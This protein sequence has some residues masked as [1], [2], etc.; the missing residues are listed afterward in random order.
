M[1]IELNSNGSSKQVG[2]LTVLT[3]TL[4]YS[5]VP[6]RKPHQ[7]L[8]S[9]LRSRYLL[10]YWVQTDT[11]NPLISLG[12]RPPTD[13]SGSCRSRHIFIPSTKEEKKERNPPTTLT[14]PDGTNRNIL[15]HRVP[16]PIP[17]FIP[18]PPLQRSHPPVRPLL[19]VQPIHIHTSDKKVLANTPQLLQLI[20]SPT[21]D[22]LNRLKSSKIPYVTS[23]KR[24]HN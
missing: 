18:P 14:P 24:S 6:T 8:P 22:L 9:I 10:G 12:Q 20:V 7:T 13:W 19:P 16:T 5:G 17:T 11:A 2:N 1:D 3:T 15:Y 21:P 4:N 23:E